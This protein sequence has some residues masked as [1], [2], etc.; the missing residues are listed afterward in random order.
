MSVH[1]GYSL[2][3]LTSEANAYGLGFMPVV[4]GAYLQSL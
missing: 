2:T 3:G 4:S 1:F